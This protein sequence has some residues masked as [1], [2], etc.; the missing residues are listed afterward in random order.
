MWTNTA[1]G[2][3]GTHTSISRPANG[4]RSVDACAD[5]RLASI[6]PGDNHMAT[7]ASGGMREIEWAE[8]LL[9]PE[10]DRAMERSARQELGFVPPD[11]PYL[12]A[13]PWLSRA[14]VRWHQRRAM[15][16]RASAGP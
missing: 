9:R 13:C 3:L 11:L 14:A 12:V 4:P 15:R 10:R 5:A 7:R 2:L 1:S 16:T 6:Q 8:C